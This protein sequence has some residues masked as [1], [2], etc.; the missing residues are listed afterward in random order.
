MAG[1]RAGPADRR[2][3]HGRQSTPGRLAGRAGPRVSTPKPR[4]RMLDAVDEP[5]P[6]WQ[7]GDTIFVDLP[8]GQTVR[9]R[10]VNILENGTVR[11]VPE[12]PV[13]LG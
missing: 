13:S 12:H 7:S 6:G 9:C 10:I 4:R 3:G 11:V 1:G 8:D 2:Q 5:E